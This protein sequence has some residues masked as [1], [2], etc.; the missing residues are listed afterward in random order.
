MDW[1]IFFSYVSF[2][3]SRNILCTSCCL[4]LQQFVIFHPLCCSHSWLMC[5]SSPCGLLSLTDNVEFFVAGTTFKND[6]CVIVQPSCYSSFLMLLT[7]TNFCFIFHS[8]CCS[9]SRLLCYSSF[10]VLL[11]L[12]TFVLFFIPRAAYTD[13]FCVIIHSSCCLHWHILCY[14]LS[15]VLLTLTTFLSVFLSWTSLTHG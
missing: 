11:T 12:T 10:L 4:L 2:P 3:T 1:N 7:L 15:L 9:H 8:S 6:Y 14:A 5:Y 13:E